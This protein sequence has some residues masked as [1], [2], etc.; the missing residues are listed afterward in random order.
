MEVTM[1]NNNDGPATATPS[2]SW[3]ELSTYQ[4]VVLHAIHDRAP[5]T[6]QGLLDVLTTVYDDPAHP[7]LYQNLDRLVEAGLVVKT[8]QD[9]DARTNEY[10]LTTAGEQ[11]IESELDWK[12]QRLEV[13]DGD[14]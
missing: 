6:G 2:P 14:E 12:N 4:T 3:P 1:P 9:A 11:R 13:R 8:R 7:T 10:R 5:V